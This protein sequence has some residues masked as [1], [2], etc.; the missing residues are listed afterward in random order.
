MFIQAFPEVILLY[1]NFW[2]QICSILKKQSK[3]MNMAV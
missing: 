3:I 2:N 1:M